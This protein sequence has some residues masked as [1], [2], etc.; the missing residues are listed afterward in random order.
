MKE[1]VFLHYSQAELDRNYDQRGWIANAEEIIARYI[2]RSEVTRRILVQ[3]R[4]VPYGSHP[5]EILDIFPT[6]TPGAPTLVF[7]HGGAWRNFTKDDFSFVVQA[8]V[9]AGIHVVIVNFSKLP[10]KRL[11]DVIAQVRSAVIWVWWHAHEFN[12]DPDRLYLCGHSSGAHMTATLLLA[13]WAAFGV[14][15]DVIK[16]A[17]CISGSYD[18]QPVVLSTR[19]SY[20]KLNETEVHRLSPVRHVARIPCPVLVA[21]AEHDTDEFQRHAREFAA[22]LA[23]ANKL[24]ALLCLPGINHFEI[25]ELLA[26]PESGLFTTVLS[27]IEEAAPKTSRSLAGE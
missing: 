18:L 16:G 26:E 3:R 7:F 20:I 5:D 9:P 14:P 2:A 21:Y 13:D 8:L 15:C 19:G 23:R 12:G 22:S 17:A 1:N 6:G 27:H 4:N 24:S 25:I 10:A 11:P